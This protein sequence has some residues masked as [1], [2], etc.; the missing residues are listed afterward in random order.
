MLTRSLRLCLNDLIVL[1][2]N[3]ENGVNVVLVDHGVQL[4]VDFVHHLIQGLV[5]DC[6]YLL[7]QLFIL[8]YHGFFQY[9]LL[10]VF[11]SQCVFL[12]VL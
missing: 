5:L 12:E 7:L 9:L 8:F 11:V 3:L 6:G 4:I 1:L 10:L 2:C